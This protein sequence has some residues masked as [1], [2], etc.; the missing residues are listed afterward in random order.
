MEVLP[1]V[2]SAQSH[3]KYC[4]SK[5]VTSRCARRRTH[6]VNQNHFKW[7][8]LL[9]SDTAQQRNGLFWFSSNPKNVTGFP[10]ACNMFMTTEWLQGDYHV[11]DSKFQSIME[12]GQ[13]SQFQHSSCLQ[14]K[15]S[16]GS[17]YTWTG[18]LSPCNP[19]TKLQLS[20][21]LLRLQTK[22]TE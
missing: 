1:E 19:L 15:H 21:D 2:G 4:C 13:Q 7:L 22:G 9:G 18:H 17:I 14:W 3:G 11:L 20:L 10:I 8:T 12:L 6:K 5:L 16:V